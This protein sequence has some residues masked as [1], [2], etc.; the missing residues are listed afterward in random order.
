MARSA[1]KALEGQ[2]FTLAAP[3]S[4]ARKQRH[5]QPDGL[6][7]AG[8]LVQVD[9]GYRDNFVTVTIKSAETHLNAAGKPVR[10]IAYYECTL[11]ALLTATA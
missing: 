1:A 5:T 8:S 9:D 2:T 3:I 4:G 7:V 6:N 10:A 11:A